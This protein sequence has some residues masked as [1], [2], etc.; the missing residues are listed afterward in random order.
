[1]H[2]VEVTAAIVRG[3]EP[4]PVRHPTSTR[5]PAISTSY[6]A[7]ALIATRA[8]DREL[9]KVAVLFIAGGLPDHLVPT[10]VPVVGDHINATRSDRLR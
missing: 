5:R 8:T 4:I 7:L 9:H 2:N 1:V 10:R 6:N 3:N